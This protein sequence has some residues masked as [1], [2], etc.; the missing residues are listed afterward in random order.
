MPASPLVQHGAYETGRTP[1]TTAQRTTFSSAT[2]GSVGHC[3]R[4]SVHVSVCAFT[5]RLGPAWLRPDGTVPWDCARVA[6]GAGAADRAPGTQGR[7]DRRARE[8]ALRAR[9]LQ[10]S[11]NAAWDTVL[12][13]GFRTVGCNCASVRDTVDAVR[14]TAPRQPCNRQHAADEMQHA[15]RCE[16]SCGRLRAVSA[17]AALPMNALAAAAAHDNVPSRA[18]RNRMPTIRVRR[19][20]HSPYRAFACRSARIVW[21]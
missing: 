5:V 3:V 11:Y 18:R 16:G 10:Q 8:P 7:A 1:F 4:R 9:A 12:G 17:V 6:K 19:I 13:V 21:A 15:A 14:D 2:T 20:L